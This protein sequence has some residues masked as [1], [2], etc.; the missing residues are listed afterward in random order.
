MAIMLDRA[1]NTV[2]TCWPVDHWSATI[3]FNWSRSV[4]IHLNMCRLRHPQLQ[5]RLYPPTSHRPHLRRRH[6]PH[7]RTKYISIH[8]S[9]NSIPIICYRTLQMF[10][11]KRTAWLQQLLRDCHCPGHRKRSRNPLTFTHRGW[12]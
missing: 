12:G 7:T 3:R 11:I 1:V 4:I 6:R 9:T 8:I 2:I 5:I 10:H